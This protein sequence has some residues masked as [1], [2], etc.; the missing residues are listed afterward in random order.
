MTTRRKQSSVESLYGRDLSCI[1]AAG[2]GGLATGAAPEIERRL[3]SAAIPIRR[4]VDVGCGAGPLTAALVQAGF[5]T[6]G[7]DCSSELLSIARRV[8]PKASFVNASVYDAEI[9]ACE[10]IIAL[11]EPL[12][13]HAEG[14]DAERL[15]GGFFQRASDVLPAGGL[16]IFDVI[17]LGEPSLSGRFWSSGDDWAVLAN[18]TED[19]NARTLVR[20]IETFRRVDRL[21]RRGREI[22]RVRLFDTPALLRRLATCGFTAETATAYGSQRLGPR[23]RAFFC[24]RT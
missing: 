4:V 13:Y 12:T 3:S 2:F 1:Q 24:S 10:A 17:E 7:I 11:G 6:T 8:A 16:L 21:Y 14:V 18:N 20:C 15:V 22:H 5:E 19:Q 9:P 23:R